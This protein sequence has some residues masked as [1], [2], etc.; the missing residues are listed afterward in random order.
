MVENTQEAVKQN[1]TYLHGYFIYDTLNMF[2]NFNDIELVFLVHHIASMY[3]LKYISFLVLPVPYLA[4]VIAM[5]AE[6]QNP[7]INFRY[8]ITNNNFKQINKIILF[9]MYLVFRIIL[10]PIYSVLFLLSFE[11][12]N[13]IFLLFFVGIYSLS[14]FWFLEMKK[15]FRM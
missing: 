1:L 6:I 10:F 9:Y 11:K 13:F 8:L 7:F 12:I 5:I 14:L 4:N 2:L 3:I 15:K